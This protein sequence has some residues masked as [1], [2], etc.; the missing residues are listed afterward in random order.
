MR[1]ERVELD[2]FGHFSAA[3]WPLGEGLTVLIGR[4]EAG[5]TTLL[6]AIRALLFGFEATRDGRAWYPA[7]AGG[8]RGG[9]L[10][11]STARGERWTIER[12]GER[13]GAGALSVR[14]PNGNTGGQET[15]DRLLHGADRD[16]FNN[17]FAFGL[18]ELQS[19]SSLSGDAVRGR[20][21]GAG[22]G[23]GGMSALDLEKRLRVDQEAVFLPGGRKQRLNKILAEIEELQ[24]RIAERERE[25]AEYEAARRELGDLLVGVAHLREERLVRVEQ[26]ERLRRLLLAQAPAADL[27]LLERE[28]AAGDATLDDLSTDAVAALDRGSAAV[29]DA[30]ATVLDL[31]ERLATA[32][33][34]REALAVD[35]AVLAE[36]AGIAALRDERLIHAQRAAQRQEAAAAIGRHVA[37]IDDQRRRVGG[38]E[39]ERLLAVDDS[40]A[41]VETTRAT[42]R[43]LAEAGTLVERLDQRLTAAREELHVAE[44]DGAP[45]GRPDDA[46]IG[47]ARAIFGEIEA[48]Q[49]RRN[50][51]EARALFAGRPDA[52]G[53]APAWTMPALIVFLAAT[54][55]LAGYYFGGAPLGLS[56]GLASGLFLA[57]IAW[58]VLR[59]RRSST[60]AAGLDEERAALDRE[61]ARLLEAAGLA[62]DAAP[63]AVAEAAAELAALRLGAAEHGQRVARLEAR[64]KALEPLERDHERAR[65]D[66]DAAV[67]GWEAWLAERGFATATSPEAARQTLAASGLARRAVEERDEQRRRCAGIELEA[68]AYDARLDALFLR[69][70]RPLP[71][72]PALRP[73][74]LVRLAEE[75]EHSSADRRNR[76]ELDAALIELERRHAN[77]V[78]ALAERERWLAAHLAECAAA[79]PAALRARAASAAER[80][81]MVQRR[82]ELRASLAGIAGGE[83]AVAAVLGEAAAADPVSLEARRHD[84]ESEVARLEAAEAEAFTRRGALEA[85]IGRLETSEEV[86]MLRQQLAL[87]EGQAALEAR[88]WAVRAVALRLLE[89][90]RRRHERERQPQVVRDAERYFEAITGG[91]YPRILAPP[92]EANVQVETDGG[93]AR[94]TDELSRGTA[95]QLYLA[96]RFGLIEQ[97]A[98][99]AEP[100]PVVM[101]DILVNFDPGRAGRAA[102]AIRQLAERHQVLYFT[103]HPAAGELLDPD[104]ERTIELA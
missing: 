26:H 38:W 10:I 80:R 67:A 48:L 37:E 100:L 51:L 92:G 74:A 79:D 52:G 58:V 22:S 4:N 24:A 57:G 76:D 77:A 61:R 29:D 86:G 96:L 94:M 27:A 99:G 103:C 20:I 5:K 97:F 54:G 95:E 36:A 45:D 59:R 14:A 66:R 91:R 88:S 31:E 82:R 104:H 64:R 28:L 62:P 101:D 39:E 13:G 68:R 18:G 33:D 87:L 73:A 30:R 42:D 83:A 32:R 9:R 35:D 60:P 56:A 98:R 17:I 90:T 11:V 63:A 41:A 78:E 23:L 34:R 2:G 47:R 55:L 12:H 1:L 50:A 16:L 49:Q 43:R 8:R 7:L 19:F 93:A 6:N 44:S 46:E 70:G 53:A 85:S 89:E 3:A 25:P 15:L 69:L 72:D 75:L 81:A 84:A 40:I 21:Y 102:I 71:A 65:T